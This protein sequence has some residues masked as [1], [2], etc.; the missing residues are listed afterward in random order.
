MTEQEAGAARRAIQQ[1]EKVGRLVTRSL[2]VLGFGALIFT[3]V[4]VTTFAVQ[5]HVP[6]WVAWML[7][8]LASLALLTVLYVDGALAEQGDYRA[9]GWPFVLRWFAGLSTWI[10]NCWQSLYPDG[11]FRL[12]PA[13]ADAGGLLLHSMAPVLLIILAEASA[14]YRTYLAA[15]TAAH[16]G[17]IRAWEDT[18]AADRAARERR[19]REERERAEAAER[20][21]AREAARVARQQ[22]ERE[23]EREAR[24]HSARLAREAQ[25]AEIER[26]RELTRI[27]QEKEERAARR[28]AER[29]RFEAE[30]EAAEQDRAAEREALRNK[31]EAEARAVAE[32]ERVKR[33]AAAERRERAQ[34]SRA[35]HRRNSTDGASKSGLAAASIS[36]EPGS[37][38]EGRVPREIRAAQREKAE[39]EAAAALLDGRTPDPV[40]LAQRYGLGETWGGDRVRA[41]RRRLEEE[42]GFEEAVIFS[43]LEA[44]CGAVEAPEALQPQGTRP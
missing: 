14:G 41:A 26:A 19:A 44:E 42:D 28:E 27:E 31:A 29:L 6:G 43:V 1:L 24:E 40:A 3:C 4:N 32:A 37:K 38:S 8:P 9:S 25:Q 2:L 36:E 5:H 11:V 22:D 12:V 23:A 20:E 13:Q 21:Q 30:I 18:L 33:Q 7:D 17:T 15:R 10:M 39:R 34:R 35:K 16:R